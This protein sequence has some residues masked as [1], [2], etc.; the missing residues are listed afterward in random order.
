MKG[1]KPKILKKN[2]SNVVLEKIVKKFID[3]RDPTNEY[4]QLPLIIPEIKRRGSKHFYGFVKSNN[5]EGS[6]LNDVEFVK[7]INDQRVFLI[8]N[9]LLMFPRAL[10]VISRSLYSQK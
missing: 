6:I 3:M 8:I 1:D 10:F 9:T 7:T 4:Y 5:G 2:Q